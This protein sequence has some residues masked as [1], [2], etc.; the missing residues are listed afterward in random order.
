M[1]ASVKDMKSFKTSKGVRLEKVLES[2][3]KEHG[4][5]LDS[6]LG[7]KRALAGDDHS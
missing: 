3:G 5:G 2:D 4:S 7:E 1:T 6:V